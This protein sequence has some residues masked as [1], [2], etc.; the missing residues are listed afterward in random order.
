MKRCSM[1]REEGNGSHTPERVDTVL[2]QN[3]FVD[4]I[5]LGAEPLPY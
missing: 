4:S 1:P 2:R 5:V 3:P